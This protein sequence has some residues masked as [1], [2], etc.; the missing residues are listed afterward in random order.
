MP[1]HGTHSIHTL[2]EMHKSTLQRTHRVTTPLFT[3]DFRSTLSRSLGVQPTQRVGAAAPGHFS[4][5]LK[6][7]WAKAL[8]VTHAHQPFSSAGAIQGTRGHR[9]KLSPENQHAIDTAVDTA[10]N[11]FRVPKR[12]LSAVIHAE[13]GFN[14]QAV[15]PVGAKGLMQLMDGTAKNLGVR[16]S[17]DIH[18]NVMGGAKY[19]RQ[20][21]DQFGQDTR[22]ALAAYN[23]GPGAVQK[24]NGVP[25]YRETQSYVQR[26]MRE[27]LA[28]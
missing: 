19:L 5:T 21:L 25:P 12:L 7:Y 17:F 8:P 9:Y 20:M 22:L 1:L 28:G 4:V 13:S 27:Y 11:T 26:I 3:K 23:A 18:E 10:C 16:N 14:P 24:Y 6:D 2:E 15:S